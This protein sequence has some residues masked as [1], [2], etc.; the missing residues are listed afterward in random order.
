MVKYPDNSKKNIEKLIIQRNYKGIASLC[1]DY[2][3]LIRILLK[4]NMNTFVKS[5]NLYNDF[6]KYIQ[7]KALQCK[8]QL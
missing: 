5:K 2:D 8:C 7:N 1:K 3:L 6:R 4:D